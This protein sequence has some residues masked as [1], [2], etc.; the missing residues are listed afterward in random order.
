MSDKRKRQREHPTS[1]RFYKELKAKLKADAMR[2]NMSLGA[3][4]IKCCEGKPSPR[5]V[6]TT[7]VEKK[8][9]CK[10]LVEL[11]AI[12]KALIEHTDDD[13]EGSLS[14]AKLCHEELVL[15]RNFVFSNTGRKP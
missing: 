3:Y 14:A 2:A 5:Q 1:V 4:I 11:A 13:S 9:L 6:R 8:L 12:K 7:P 10:V 15:L